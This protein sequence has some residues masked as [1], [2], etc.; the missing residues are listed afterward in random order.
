MNIAAIADA[1]RALEE[2][3][4]PGQGGDNNLRRLNLV[5]FV[6][7]RYGAALVADWKAM[8]QRLQEL[9]EL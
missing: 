2:Y 1:E 3:R 7:E 4:E 8:R 9:G 5:A 6:G